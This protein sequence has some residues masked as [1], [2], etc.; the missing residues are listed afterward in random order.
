M[1]EENKMV[2]VN[3]SNTK[4]L[5]PFNCDYFGEKQCPSR[6]IIECLEKVKRLNYKT[7]SG[8]KILKLIENQK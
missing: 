2:T 3:I 7:C 6:G 5:H 4:N 1:E 8:Y